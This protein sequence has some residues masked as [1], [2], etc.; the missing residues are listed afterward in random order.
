MDS[1]LIFKF[2]IGDKVRAASGNVG[3]ITKCVYE[4]NEKDEETKKYYVSFGTYDTR[5]IVEDELKEY[6]KFEFT[7]KYEIAFL[8]FLIDIYLSERNFDL[9]KKCIQLKNEYEV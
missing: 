3:E 7:K 2:S 1:R 5:Y 9:V 6:H 8:D 4:I